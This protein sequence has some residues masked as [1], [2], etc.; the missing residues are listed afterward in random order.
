MKVFSSLLVLASL[1]AP[2]FQQ[3]VGTGHTGPG[4]PN[5]CSGRLMEFHVTINADL[6]GDITFALTDKCVFEVVG[7]L[8]YAARGNHIYTYCL[9]PLRHYGFQITDFPGNVDVNNDHWSLM[10]GTSM[11]VENGVITPNT[12]NATVFGPPCDSGPDVT[13]DPHCK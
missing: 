8:Q 2:S 4:N 11:V 3:A 7:T 5:S 10:W 13:G 6:V 1:F 9:D 12:Q